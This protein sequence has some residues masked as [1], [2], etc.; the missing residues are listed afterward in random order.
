NVDFFLFENSPDFG[1]EVVEQ[2]PNRVIVYIGG[3]VRQHLARKNG[4]GLAIMSGFGFRARIDDLTARKHPREKGLS[5]RIALSHPAMART[6]RLFEII[7]S[8]P[9]AI[10]D[11]QAPGDLELAPRTLGGRDDREALHWLIRPVNPRPGRC[12]GVRPHALCRL[13]SA[14]RSVDYTEQPYSAQRQ[15]AVHTIDRLMVCAP[16]L[17]EP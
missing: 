8:A 12:V 2:C 13:A 16:A 10:A 6:D 3:I 15:R 1:G 11:P 14:A 5:T 17:F 7:D 9:R 4:N